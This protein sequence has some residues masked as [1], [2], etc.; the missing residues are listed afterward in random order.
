[1]ARSEDDRLRTGWILWGA[2]ALSHLMLGAVFVSIAPNPVHHRGAMTVILPILTVATTLPLGAFIIEGALARR[3]LR[4]LRNRR[5]LVP[6]CLSGLLVG[7]AMREAGAILAGV[8]LVLA[9]H[10]H[11]WAFAA[12]LAWISHLAAIPSVRRM[13]RWW[14][15]AGGPRAGA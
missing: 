9:G 12:G 6:A 7:W 13:E 10:F 15:A 5:G 2:I 14:E 8:G 1:M 11:L 4:A 3:P